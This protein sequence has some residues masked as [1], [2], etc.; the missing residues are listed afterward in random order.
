M[1][2]PQAPL[3]VERLELAWWEVEVRIA[4]VCPVC[5]TFFGGKTNT[6]GA[7]LHLACVAVSRDYHG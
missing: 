7:A 6:A 2:D 4:F 5:G 3:Q 1:N